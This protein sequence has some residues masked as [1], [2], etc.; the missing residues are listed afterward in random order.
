M[1]WAGRALGGAIVGAVIVLLLHPATRPQ[2]APLYRALSGRPDAWL[3]SPWRTANA[4]IAPPLAD[5]TA[6]A[7]WLLLGAEQSQLGRLASK[8]DNQLYDL[9]RLQAAREPDNAFW[10]QAAALFAARLRRAPEESVA[11]RTGGIALRYNDYQTERLVRIAAAL[12]AQDSASLPWHWGALITERSPTLAEIIARRGTQRV[13]TSPPQDPL[14]LARRAEGLANAVLMR[15]GGRRL[16]ISLE[17]MDWIE[18]TARTGPA[19]ESANQRRLIISRYALVDRFRKAGED[20]S[21]R[22]A[23]NAF[24]ENDAWLALAPLEGADTFRRALTSEAL[25]LAVTPS[26]CLLAA[27]GGF[28]LAMIGF[29]LRFIAPAVAW[30]TSA[31]V[32]PVIGITVALAVYFTTQRGLESFW[33]FMSLSFFALVP[34][35]KRRADPIW[36]GPLFALVV[37]SLAIGLGTIS[38]LAFARTTAAWN[39]LAP[40]L[41][42]NTVAL[43]DGLDLRWVATVLAVLL[44]CV[45]PTWSLVQRYA[46]PPMLSRVLVTAG[47]TVAWTFAT[48]LVVVTLYST[49]T[50]VNLTTRLRGLAENEAAYHLAHG[51]DGR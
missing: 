12:R 47:Q 34:S 28:V 49:I 2:F 27:L 10:H 38:A 42:T 11:W 25:L 43:L 6:A 23:A 33:L 35:V 48:A 30:A 9:A 40:Q 22:V 31:R 20:Q 8:E 7:Y 44:V 26:G 51:H 14:D 39:S 16:V 4:R 29:G 13:Q 37:G 17:G 5:S 41:G 46:V 21:A 24:S 18:A 45:A 3:T 19:A 50:N 1:N 32:A 15:D 36:P